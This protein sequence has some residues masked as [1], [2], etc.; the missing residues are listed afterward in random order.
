MA[1]SVSKGKK[2]QLK[3]LLYLGNLD[4][5]EDERQ[6]LGK[7]I[8][9]KLANKPIINKFSD[10]I[11]TI[12]DNA[13][14]AYKAK[15]ENAPVNNKVIA[16]EG[17]KKEYVEMDTDSLDHTGSRT[18]GAETLS[19]EFY[20]RL[21]FDEIFTQCGFN[22]A[23]KDLCKAV[24][25][26]RLIS[27]GSELHTYKW[28]KGE[29][30]LSEFLPTMKEDIPFNPLYLIG[31]K[32]YDKKAAIENK[33]RLK[34]K[35]L[36]PEKDKVYL[37]D[38]TNTY[39]ESSKTKSKI[40]K[41]GKSKEKRT[42]CPLV[43]L[44]LVVDQNGFPVYSKIF[45]GN[46]S[47]PAT[48]AEILAK[49][50]ENQNDLITMFM[51]PAIVMDRGIA[52][53][54]NVTYLEEHDYSYF[55]IERKND[56]K[57]YEKEFSEKAKFAR[58]ETSKKDWILLRKIT[59]E[60]TDKVLVISSGKAH[61]EKS[62]VNKKEKR[63]LEDANKL[64]SSNNKGYIQDYEKINIRIGRLKERY[65]SIT[66]S[67]RFELKKDSANPKKVKSIKLASTKKKM[68]KKEYA[69]HYVIRTNKKDL[70]AKEIWEFYMKLTGVES[71]F[72]SLKSELGTRPVYHQKDDRIEAHLF[73]S[74]LAY[75]ILRS[76]TFS[77]NKMDYH[78]S[79]SEIR[80]ILKMHIR[81]NIYYTDRDGN[82]YKVRMTGKPEE[83]V[84]KIYDLLKI[85]LHR[86]KIITKMKHR[87]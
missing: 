51:K 56:V 58:Y 74:V 68:A 65:G 32:I 30:M 77:L 34:T 48:L 7:L 9:F 17:K 40:C 80:N 2:R 76:I 37:Y 79:W 20:Q 72:R 49:V 4:I 25:L 70:T 44:A 71:S 59:G 42:D 16:D 87:K 22:A 19:L 61:K 64:I 53:D 43:T 26:G 33:L 39:F 27:P 62:I 1:E 69:G 75:H 86:Y 10:K 14:Q 81:A 78:K 5:S 57:N 83:E 66:N 41:R 67:Y 21:G 36:F 24:I 55:V 85:K 46:Q 60:S 38:L 82:N 54:D 28:L 52:T 3:K 63:F 11:E 73:I 47:E 18:A 35:A 84:N 15:W 8:E 45:K 29:S 6:I 31:D 12:S 50:Y 13:V 23:E